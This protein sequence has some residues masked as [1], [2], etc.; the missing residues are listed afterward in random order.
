MLLRHSLIDSITILLTLIHRLRLQ[1]QFHEPRSALPCPS[2]IALSIC[3][4]FS[5]RPY[6]FAI[7]ESTSA[8]IAVSRRSTHGTKASSH[9]LG[10]PG[11]H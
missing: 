3:C 9:T 11:T 8:I 2:I 1:P 5:S 6:I 7:I 10:R 4:S